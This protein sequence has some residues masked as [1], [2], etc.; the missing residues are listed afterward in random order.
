MLSNADDSEYP[1]YRRGTPK[2]I[3]LTIATGIFD[4]K[5]KEWC[6][7]VDNAKTSSP[8]A[9]FPMEI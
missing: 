8:I 6:M 1:I 3:A 7:Y 2:D 5:R 9:V 4:F